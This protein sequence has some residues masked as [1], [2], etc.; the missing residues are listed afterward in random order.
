MKTLAY[1]VNIEK[2]FETQDKQLSD[3]IEKD[4]LYKEKG[5]ENKRRLLNIVLP[6]I[7][8]IYALHN[9]KCQ[10]TGRVSTGCD[11]LLGISKVDIDKEI[12]FI[13]NT[14]HHLIWGANY[15]VLNF[16]IVSLKKDIKIWLN[17]REGCRQ[18]TPH[19]E[20]SMLSVKNV[21]GESIEDE[22]TI[23]AQM[24]SKYTDEWK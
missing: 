19:L 3:N 4:R 2:L 5:I 21:Y 17:S 9:R 14:D 24:C 7:H 6:Y 8:S 15:T 16:R 12:D 1:S 13:V 23:I 10:H 20:Y 22:L 11:G 18:S